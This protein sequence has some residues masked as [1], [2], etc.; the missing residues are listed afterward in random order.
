[1]GAGLIKSPY[2]YQG[3]KHS[4]IET[5]LPLM[6]DCRF[7]FDMFGGSGTV[8]AS[9]YNSNKFQAV[10]Y[11]ELSFHT[12]RIVQALGHGEF[13]T[14]R[15][16]INHYIKKYGLSKTNAKGFLQMREDVNRSR[17]PIGFWMLS[18]HSHSNL[19]R[20][21]KKGLFNVQFGNRTI[22]HR[23]PAV[24]EELLLFG[25]RMQNVTIV[26]DHYANVLNSLAPSKLRRGFFYFDPPYLASGAHAYGSWTAEDDRK[27]M[28]NLDILSEA[29]S[30]WMLSNVLRHRHFENLPLINWSKKYNVINTD[31]TYMF[32]NAQADSH[33][34]QEVI[35]T[36]Y[37]I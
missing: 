3:N 19:S 7:A 25:Q 34:T 10:T 8:A 17:C 22:E 13:K 33:S 18:R 29:G 37:K 21:N 23:L 35:I 31:K 6:P 26:G 20:F 9:M 32:A 11:V 24:L 12:E 4:L 16:K 1:M 2:I 14:V 30:K 36:N 5:L 15:R 28:A 27:L